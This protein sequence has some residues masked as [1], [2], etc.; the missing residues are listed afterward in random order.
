M[1]RRFNALGGPL[2]PDF[3]VNS[4]TSAYQR[5][6]TIAVDGDGDFV[7]TWESQFQDG[8]SYGVFAQ[9]FAASGARI[10]TELQVNT[11][12]D[13]SQRFP[14]VAADEKGGFVV[15]WSSYF[16][17]GSG[18]GAFGQRLAR[19][20]ALDVDGNGVFDP[21]TDGLLIL[22]FGFGFSGQTLTTGAVGSGCTRCDASSIAEYLET[23]S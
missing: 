17:D 13:N 12:T 23:M 1:A 11:Y 16:Q 9:A 2:G 21:L 7:V 4:Y 14:E 20:V 10:G 6:P 5:Y 8:S 19:L 22:R 3:L 18:Q 15:V